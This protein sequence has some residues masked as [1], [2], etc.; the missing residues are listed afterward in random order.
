MFPLLFAVPVRAAERLVV[1]FEDMSIPIPIKDLKEW[2]DL[3]VRK[4]TELADWLS[5][6]DSQSQTGLVKLLNASLLKDRS[7]VRQLMKSWAGRQLLDELSDVIRLDDDRSGKKVLI[8]LESLLENQPEVR[9]IDLLEA[10]PA[11][12]IFLDLD[13]LLK[14]ADRWKTALREQQDLVLALGNL[15][16]QARRELNTLKELD[17]SSLIFSE[18]IPLEVPHRSVPLLLEVWLPQHESVRRSSW[19]VFMPGLGGS[20]DH[21]RWLGRELSFNGWPVVVLEHP[22]SGVKAVQELLEGKNAVP[23]AEVLPARLADLKAVINFRE[24]GGFNL[25]EEKLVLMGHSLGALTSFLASGVS[26]EDGLAERCSKALDDLSLT[27]LS[28]LL[29]CQLLDVELENQDEISDLKA[30]IAINSFGSLLWPNDRDAEIP[31]PVFLIGGTLDLITPPIQEQLGLLLATNPHPLSR[32]L[33]VEGASHFSPVRVEGQDKRERGDDLFQLDDAFVGVEPLA[34]QSLFSQEIMRYLE[35][36][37]SGKKVGSSVHE[38]KGNLRL[39]LLDR[40][41]VKDLL[42]DQ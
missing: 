33:L 8:T 28:Q 13:S 36:L 6:L 42:Y 30:I 16:T 32:T 41:A 12:S 39:H 35:S 18:L 27:N 22:G 26:P 21:F 1:E 40:Q 10:L 19:I 25:K 24:N 31:V 37:E 5:L 29:Q 2:R 7:M 38:Q 20:Q 15:Q 14:L 23:G 3:K 17:E 4:E 34:V 11:K 9:T